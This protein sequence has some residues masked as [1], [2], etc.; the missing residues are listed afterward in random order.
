MRSWPVT[1][2]LS[3]MLGHIGDMA[4]VIETADIS[5]A[6]SLVAVE[7]YHDG[8]IDRMEVSDAS[9]NKTQDKANGLRPVMSI[10]RE[11]QSLKRGETCQASCFFGFPSSSP[12]I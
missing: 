6:L 4:E 10:R 1:R 3:V 12:G 8:S 7:T 5:M 11:S 2:R 9:H